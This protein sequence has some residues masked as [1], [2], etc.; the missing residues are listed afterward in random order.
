MR[1]SLIERYHRLPS[2]PHP[3]PGDYPPGSYLNETDIIASHIL[4]SEREI[5][6]SKNETGNE[7]TRARTRAMLKDYPLA[8]SGNTLCEICIGV[9]GEKLETRAPLGVAAGFFASAVGCIDDYL[10]R[11]GDYGRYGKRLYWASHAYR[12][13]QDL[14]LDEE[15]RSG[16]LTASELGEIK[17]RLYEVILTLV[18]SERTPEPESYLYRKS[19]GDKVIAV[20][21][22]ATGADESVKSKCAEIGRLTGEAGQLIDDAMDYELDRERNNPNFMLMGGIGVADGLDG[23]ERRLRSAREASAG[24]GLSPIT[25]LL[26]TMEGLVEIFRESIESGTRPGPHLLKLSKPLASMLPKGVEA[27]KFLMWF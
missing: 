6:G 22:P 12:D 25:W 13:C 9:I 11:E 21:F 10:D 7:T 15:V 16:R 4:R 17:R 24:L 27:D 23:A 8:G 18:E 20:L 26:D 19:C 5:N 2:P 14:A 1:R 3:Y